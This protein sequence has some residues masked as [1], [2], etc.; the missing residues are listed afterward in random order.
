M[1]VITD[2]Q[3]D[4]RERTDIERS[5]FCYSVLACGHYAYGVL[6][7]L[8]EPVIHCPT[9]GYSSASTAVHRIEPGSVV[10]V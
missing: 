1:S 10:A 6:R 3:H 4:I 8:L 2:L 7:D 5:I 9:C